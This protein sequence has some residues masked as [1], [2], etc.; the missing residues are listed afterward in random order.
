MLKKNPPKGT[1]DITPQNS[2]TPWQE[3]HLW[4]HVERVSKDLAA[5]YNFSEIR[6]P[7]LEYENLFRQGI[8]ES[9]DI[10]TKEC[11]SFTDRKG[12]L[13]AL[14]PEGTAPILRAIS[15]MEKVGLQK[16]F[17][18]GPMF[19]YERPQAGRYRQHHQFGLEAFGNKSA[20]QDVEVIDLLYSIFTRLGLN[21]LIVKVNSIGDKA[22]RDKFTKS[23]VAY[24]EPMKERLSSDSQKRLSKNPLRI[25]DSKDPKDHL[26]LKDAPNIMNYFTDEEKNHFQQICDLLSALQIPYEIDNLIVRGLDYYNRTVFEIFSKEKD[27]ALGGGGRY[28]NF[29]EKFEMP[30]IPAVGAGVGIERLI[31]VLLAEKE[32]VAEKR[33]ISIFI[34]A[35]ENKTFCL[36]L[37]R[38]LRQNGITT[39]L[40]TEAKSIGQAL[41]IAKTIGSRFVAIYASEEEKNKTITLKNMDTGESKNI[42]TENCVA[43]IQKEL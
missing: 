24:L 22:S 38:D 18:I 37:A 25:L 20:E 26:L 8:G 10:V 7:I 14:R 19:R 28:D 30:P 43:L 13:L 3:V 16:F 33:R 35:I 2:K 36:K 6:T 17:Y 11:Y 41:G 40:Y 29:S 1:F 15:T 27:I 12:R 4:Q 32:S 42:P 5:L 31:Q 9:S 21:N 39:E 23:L 34:A